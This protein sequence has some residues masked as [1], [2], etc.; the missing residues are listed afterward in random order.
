MGHDGAPFGPQ[1]LELLDRTD[2]LKCDDRP[3]DLSVAVC[4][5]H[6]ADE[7]RDAVAPLILQDILGPAELFTAQRPLARILLR[8][9]RLSVRREEHVGILS[10]VLVRAAD[11][12]PRVLVDLNATAVRSM[13]E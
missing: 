3:L 4:D 1:A 7:D 12:L 5:R 9:N 13:R 2:V 6:G 10:E 8:G 11:E